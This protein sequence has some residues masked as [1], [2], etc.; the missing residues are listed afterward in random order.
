MSASNISS[1]TIASQQI[2][3]YVGTFILIIGM[4]GEILNIIVFLSLQTFRQ[5]SC[6]FYLIFMSFFNIG[7]LIF[8]LFPRIMTSGF[9]IDWTQ[10]SLFYCKFK[11]YILQI[12]S[13][14]SFTCICLA[15]ID[16][17]MATCFNPRWQQWNNIKLARS[18]CI[19]TASFWILHGIPYLVFYNIIEMPK[20]GQLTCTITN[21]IFQQYFIYFYVLILG[22]VLPISITVIFG[23]LAYRNIQQMAYRTIP[24]VRRELDKQLTVMSP[25]YI[26]ICVSERFRKQ[27]NYVLFKIHLNR[28]QLG[29]IT[30]NQVIP[31]L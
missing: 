14:T 17:F 9:V 20:T 6:A 31:K 29:N 30:L 21:A 1:L 27:L 10:T 26:Y 2:N 22:L 25:F 3:I 15:T 13:L 28:W 16:Q 11:G 4:I 23:L 5:N 18:L 12:C 19:I 24:L 7:Q 8:S